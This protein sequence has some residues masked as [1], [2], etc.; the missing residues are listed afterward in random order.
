MTVRP[1]KHDR[2][3]SSTRSRATEEL[4]AVYGAER[5]RRQLVAL[6]AHAEAIEDP[7]LWLE[8]AVRR[9]FKFMPIESVAECPCGSPRSRHLSYFVYWNLLGVRRC[10][11]C[12][13]V[14]VSPR[15]TREA[16]ERVFNEH[17]FSGSDQVHWDERRIP[18]FRD[19]VRLLRRYDCESVLDI[20]SAYGRFVKWA[21]DEGFDASGSDISTKAVEWGRA[22]LGVTLHVGQ[23]VDLEIPSS[24]F[25]CITCLDTLYYSTDPVSELSAMR[26]LLKADG[27]LI[28]RLRNNSFA[29]ARASREGR[30]RVGRVVLPL[31]HLWG[32]TPRTVR[33][34][35]ERSGFQIIACEPAA[36]SRTALAPLAAAAVWKNRILTRSL[37]IPPLT[38]SFNVVA[39]AAES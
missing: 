13:L 36:Y 4:T 1:R 24:S 16:M 28:L 14:F 34:V 26:A 9:D 30:K 19:V 35:L 29:A 23:V 6:E 33:P 21:A 10:L 8:V 37:G 25:D 2:R 7:E 17:Y 5:V 31:P 32:F 15:L 3:R 38:H 18:V 11:D 12:G 39:R 22:N 27:H 20:G